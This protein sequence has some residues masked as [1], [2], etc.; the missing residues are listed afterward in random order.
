MASPVARADRALA[1]LKDAAAACG[2][3]CYAYDLG[4]LGLQL[5]RL[6]K[7]LPPRIE[8][9]YSL[10]ANPLPDLCQIIAGH[11]LGADVVSLGELET[12]LAAG[13]AAER[14]QVSG[15]YKPPALLERLRG[16]AGVV[17]SVDSPSELEGLAAR[18]VSQNRLIVRLRPDFT[19][20]GA[21][22]PTGPGSRFGVPL[23]ELP[24][25]HGSGLAI[26]GFHIFAGSQVLDAA[27]VVSNLRSS[28]ELGLRA[29]EVLGI[30]MTTVNLGGGFGVPYEE[31]GQELDLRPVA[32]ELDHLAERVAPAR[33]ALEL[34]RYLV[35]Q[36][37]WYLT[38]VVA[39]QEHRG[40]RA[41]V[42]DGGVHQ[43]AD[44]CG[45][46]LRRRAAPPTVLPSRG[47]GRISTDV[48]GCLCLPDDVLA[49]AAWLPK[50]ELGDIL[51]FPNAGAYGL[52]A[53]PV[54]FLGHP[55]PAEVSFE[56]AAATE[57]EGLA[58]EAP[59]PARGG[60]AAAVAVG[61]EEKV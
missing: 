29:A 18:G 17:L 1:G 7:V 2:T 36:C 38:R 20:A 30:E 44:L 60:V 15:P 13:F 43:R 28:C 33:I 9:R 59:P 41:V 42:V 14:V 26:T 50:L 37:G 10:K 46:D 54:L 53:S 52:T 24:V 16:L 40:R 8:I 57:V 5:A 58:S 6:R 3:P 32:A 27:A 49:E 39:H 25:C 48:L 45:L 23:A 12:A 31:G 35:A 55:P 56:S 19:P 4:R 34:G 61:L 51:A 22:M 47:T 21:V 11:G